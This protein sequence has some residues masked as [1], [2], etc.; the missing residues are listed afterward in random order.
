MSVNGIQT[1]GYSNYTAEAYSSASKATSKSSGKTTASAE[2]AVV[3]ES[4]VNKMSDEERAQL[5]QKLK[6]ET[7]SRVNQF[8][9]LVE[10]MLLK[11]GH[12]VK[13]SDDIWSMLASGKLEV[14]P[15]TAAKAKEEISEDGY[16]GVK[17]TSERIFDMAVA[18][19]G[20]D[21]DKMED[22]LNAFK[23][24][25]DQATK[26]WGKSLPDISHKTYDAVMEKFENYKAAE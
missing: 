21:E 20:G 14:D 8:K 26:A 15:E 23:K 24:G 22:M 19:S 10:D 25:F 2:K 6:A 13:N 9:S 5:V 7:Q 17:Q 18:L 1:N 16:W 11:Q 4:S 12:K 3:Y